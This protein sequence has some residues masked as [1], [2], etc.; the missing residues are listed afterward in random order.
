[1]KINTLNSATLLKYCAVLL[2]T[3]VLSCKK[4]STYIN[5]PLS[6]PNQD[7]YVLADGNLLVRYNAQN[8]KTSSSKFTI[9]GLVSG[10]EK[11]LTIDFRPAT[12]DLYAISDAN[13]LYT[14]NISTGKATVVVDRPFSTA[15][16]GAVV[17]MDFNPVTDQ[18]RVVSNTGQN[19]R[20][21]PETATVITSDTNISGGAVMGIAHTS[22]FSGATATILYDIDP[23]TK[24]LYKQE[25]NSGV[26]T[27]VADLGLD[28]GDNVSLDISPDSKNVLMVGKVGNSLNLYSIDL[29]RNLTKLAGI[30]KDISSAKGIAI[31]SIPAAYAIG[32]G[33]NNVNNLIYFSPI[34]KTALG[35]KTITGLQTGETILGIDMRPA[36]GQ[37]YALGSSGRL[38]TINL[39]TAEL[40]QV[41]TGTFATPL[42]GTNFGFDFSAQED[43]IR[44]IS[45][46]GQN[47]TIDPKDAAVTP[48]ANLASGTTISAAA[49]SNITGPNISARLYVIDHVAKKLFTLDQ[50]SGILTPV[51]DLRF[52]VDANNGFDIGISNIGDAAYGIFTVDGKTKLYQVNLSTGALTTS[53]ALIEFTQPATITGFTLGRRL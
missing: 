40:T 41:G 50:L 29:S 25:P 3:V 26:L 51:G 22:S 18:I 43:K 5:L 17:S 33:A 14:I 52:T 9:T 27:K 13:K 10:T 42:V 34:G 15:I 44:V 37:V 32:L 28:V 11:L 12:G 48:L 35:T 53:D 16:T 1:M 47:L 23:T 7:F 21:N 19:L 2:L 38:Y 39:G 8:I 30:F 31:P 45:N 46:T 20:I 49:Y 4:E 36:N 6:G 24:I